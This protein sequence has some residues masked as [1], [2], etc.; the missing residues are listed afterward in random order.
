MVNFDA[1]EYFVGDLRSDH[2]MRSDVGW[3]SEEG[4]FFGLIVKSFM[5]MEVDALALNFSNLIFQY[6]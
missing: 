3:T 2:L 1:L 4:D 6:S 5:S